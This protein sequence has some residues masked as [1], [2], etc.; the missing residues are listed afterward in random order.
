MKLHDYLITDNGLVRE[1]N[2]DAVGHAREIGL[3]VLA[4]GMGGA[5]AGEVASQT[6]VTEVLDFVES[7]VKAAGEKKPGDEQMLSILTESLQKSNIAIYDLSQK[8]RSKSGMGTTAAALWIRNHKAY[9]AHVGDSRIYL[10]RDKKLQQLTED[11]TRVN[12]MLKLGLITKEQAQFHPARH[13]ITRA[14]GAQ[15]A[16]QID[17]L[18]KDVKAGDIF[19]LCSDGLSNKIDHEELEI[20]LCQSS[21][22]EE[23]ARKLISVARDNGGEDN[24]SAIVVRCGESAVEAKIAPSQQPVTTADVRAITTYDGFS[25]QVVGELAKVSEV[26]TFQVGDI[27]FSEGDAGGALYLILDGG[28]NVFKTLDPEKGIRRQMAE[29]FAGDFFGEISWID[30]KPRSATVVAG[31][32]SRM[33][34]LSCEVFEELMWRDPATA[35]SLLYGI[36]RSVSRRMRRMNEEFERVFRASGKSAR[37]IHEMEEILS[38]VYSRVL[39]DPDSMAG[40]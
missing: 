35:S 26:K 32:E 8:D 16:V 36:I 15:P 27:I 11:H 40:L 6:L 7:A 24:I 1:H 30:K 12:E 10:L 9:V 13:V 19:L 20:R 39:K 23:K 18:V 17:T 25:A 31:K 37:D 22:E 28:A 38:I 34:C 2:E 3:Y 29:L 21:S 4:D 14:V 5:Q 33:L